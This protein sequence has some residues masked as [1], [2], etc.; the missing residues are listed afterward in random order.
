VAKTLIEIERDIASINGVSVVR[1][2]PEKPRTGKIYYVKSSRDASAGLWVYVGS[3][4][5][6]VLSDEF[7]A[8]EERV[9]ILE[10]E[11]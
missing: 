4:Q 2:L 1:I 10:E 6:L 5:S 9:T 8:L 3:W 11:Q 7:N